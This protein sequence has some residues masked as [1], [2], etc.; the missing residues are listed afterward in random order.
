ME[1]SAPPS[2]PV[3]P[4]R[5]IISLLDGI[6]IRPYHP[7]A[8]IATSAYHANNPRIAQWMTNSFPHPYTE[9]SARSWISHA[10]SQTRTTDFVIAKDGALIG[11]IGLKPMTDIYAHI[12]G[13]GYWIGEEHW[14]RGIGKQV[15]KAFTTWALQEH[16]EVERVEAE[17]SAA[18]IGSERVLLRCGYVCEAK[19]RK[20]V[21][22][23]GVF[24]DVKIFAVLR[25]EWAG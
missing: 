4:P 1:A 21:C 15:V 3:F 8:D 17:V 2:Q 16:P 25:E 11:G 13:I 24:S 22:K 23:H 5:P 10:L 19:L 14:G 12:V 7:V 20:R 18:N 9:E 6:T